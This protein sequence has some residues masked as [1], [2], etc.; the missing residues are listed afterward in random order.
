MFDANAGISHSVRQTDENDF[1]HYGIIIKIYSNKRAERERER[2]RERK[3]QKKCGE[4]KYSSVH[5]SVSLY[6][7]VL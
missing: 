1:Y 5:V 3:T 4:V 7:Q 2:A 6:M